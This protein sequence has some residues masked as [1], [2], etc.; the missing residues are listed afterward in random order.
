MVSQI[1]RG[2]QD[3]IGAARPSIADPFLPA[4]IREGRED[5]IRECIGCNICRAANNEG[6]HLRCTQN[7]TIAEEWRRGWH[8]ERI[9]I[10]PKR[11]KALVVGAGP[12]GLEAALSLGRRGL[13]VTLADRQQKLGGRLLAES[14]L[15]GLATWIRVRDWRQH[16]IAKLPNVQVFPASE[17]A[18]EDIAGFGA[19]HVVLATGARWRRDAI[20]V[21]G[22]EGLQLPGALTPDDV[23][24]EAAVTGEVVIYDD[25]HYYMGGALAERLARAGHRVTLVTPNPSISSWTAMTDEIAFLHARL[26]EIGI[27]LVPSKLI[28]GYHTGSLRLSCTA[29][30]RESDMACTTLILVTGRLP[31]DELHVAL[32]EAP[33]PFGLHRI[34]DCLQ[35][36]SIADAVY[37][38]HRFARE[39]GEVA[40]AV[41]RRER[42]AL[43]DHA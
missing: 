34:G 27:T 14:T 12:A 28:R 30:G 10:Y 17:M 13:E 16:M 35:P 1:R 5:E 43:E 15:P 6:V 31:A 23:F 40:D 24:A 20:G 7:P 36:S 25:D 38:G 11:E 32:S 19:D 42:P 26:H 4:K 22:M 29:S 9:A 39:L 18:A 33:Q 41:L 2:I 8:P 21:N 37:S 3:F